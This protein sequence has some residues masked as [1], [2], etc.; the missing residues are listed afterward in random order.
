MSSSYYPP[1]AAD[2]PVTGVSL[3]SS[4]LAIVSHQS[5][6]H[7]PRRGCSSEVV[8]DVQYRTKDHIQIGT[9]TPIG[10]PQLERQAGLDHL[11]IKALI[12]VFSIGRLH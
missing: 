5:T 1:S 11:D 3:T 12:K 4:L 7:E 6:R 10:S 8:S 9:D 2:K